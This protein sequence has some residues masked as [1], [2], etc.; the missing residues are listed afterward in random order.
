MDI[1]Y[2]LE[3]SNIDL[4]RNLDNFLLQEWKIDTLV[5]PMMTH[6]MLLWLMSP[7]D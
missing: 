7:R 5:K 3:L 4:G 6:L 1:Q 2:L